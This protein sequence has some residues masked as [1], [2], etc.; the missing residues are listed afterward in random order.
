MCSTRSHATPWCLRVSSYLDVSNTFTANG[1]NSLHLTLI[2]TEVARRSQL[3]DMLEAEGMSQ[4]L[5]LLLQAS[6]PSLHRC[7]PLPSDSP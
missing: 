1:M 7:I 2:Q 3:A 4:L 6:T 5:L